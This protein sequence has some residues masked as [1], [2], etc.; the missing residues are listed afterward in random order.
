MVLPESGLRFDRFARGGAERV[1]VDIECGLESGVL[2]CVSGATPLDFRDPIT[3]TLYVLHRRFQ[4]N[5][6]IRFQHL[7]T[8]R[9]HGMLR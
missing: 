5:C 6:V 4:L 3:G 9:C 7:T 2:R 8:S 1:N